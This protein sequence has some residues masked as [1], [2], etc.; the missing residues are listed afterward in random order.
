M[1]LGVHMAIVAGVLQIL[2]HFVDPASKGLFSTPGPG[3]R[4]IFCV[5]Y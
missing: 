5:Y 4:R 2:I 3:M 1:E